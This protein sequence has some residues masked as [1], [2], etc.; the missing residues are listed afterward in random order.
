MNAAFADLPDPPYYVVTFSSCRTQGD[1]GY[2]AMADAMVQ[3]AAEQ[4]GFLGVESARGTD[5]F[6]ITNSYWKDEASIVAWKAVWRMPQPRGLDA[7][8][9][10]R[11]FRFVWRASSEPMDLRDRDEGLRLSR[12]SCRLERQGRRPFAA[13]VRSCWSA[14]EF[15]GAAFQVIATI[16]NLHFALG[17]FLSDDMAA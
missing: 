4:P 7:N 8:A 5:G 13:F 17:H 11:R 15:D 6:G 14:E 10:M 3:L 16:D 9:G 1:H 2:G 12:S